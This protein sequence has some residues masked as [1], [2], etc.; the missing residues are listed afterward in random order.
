MRLREQKWRRI[1]LLGLKFL[2]ICTRK[3]DLRR[4]YQLNLHGTN[5]K[6]L[7]EYG[8]L[9]RSFT[10]TDKEPQ[11]QEST[12]T[13]NRSCARGQGAPSYHGH[14]KLKWRPNLLDKDCCRK[15]EDDISNQEYIGRV[16][17]VL[18]IEMQFLRHAGNKCI[19]YVR[20]T[21]EKSVSSANSPLDTGGIYH[22][23]EEVDERHQGQDEEV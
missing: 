11:S 16:R 5:S 19:C 10:R 23:N 3:T 17:V 2:G 1:W 15:L 6:R 8:S 9:Y 4:S 13:V 7:T 21:L 18:G 20:P 14:A 22:G 12:F